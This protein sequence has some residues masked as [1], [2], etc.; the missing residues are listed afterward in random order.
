LIAFGAW[1]VHARAN[2]EDGSVCPSGSLH[3]IEATY[4]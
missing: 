3:P 2:S 4:V 1:P